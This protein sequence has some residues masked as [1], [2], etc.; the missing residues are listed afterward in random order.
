MKCICLN[1][2]VMPMTFVIQQLLA[3]SRICHQH[4]RIYDFIISVLHSCDDSN[5][6]ANGLLYG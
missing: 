4:D 5:L 2:K 1:G 3:N 6:S